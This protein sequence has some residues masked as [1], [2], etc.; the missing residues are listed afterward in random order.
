MCFA[1][2]RAGNQSQGM[3]DPEILCF[4]LWLCV[5]ALMRR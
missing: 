2:L 1:N 3:N 5:A 4:R